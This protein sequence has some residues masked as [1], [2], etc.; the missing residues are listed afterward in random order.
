MWT[1]SKVL[2]VYLGKVGPKYWSRHL[3]GP[4]AKSVIL[5]NNPSESFN[6]F[7]SE[8]REKPILSLLEGV[9]KFIMVRI[10]RKRDLMVKYN[11]LYVQN[12]RLS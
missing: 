9:K 12:L 8:C 4:N 3:W 10:H 6:R 1:K 11:G 7:I 2:V 5:L